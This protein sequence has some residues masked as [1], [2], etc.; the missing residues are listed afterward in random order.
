MSDALTKDRT[1]CIYWFD[2]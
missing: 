2:F 1:L